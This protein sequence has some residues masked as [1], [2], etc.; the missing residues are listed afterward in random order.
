VG[1]SLQCCLRVTVEINEI[2]FAEHAKHH[3]TELAASEV[4]EFWVLA[5]S[6]S[7]KLLGKQMLFRGTVD[8]CMVHPRDVFRFAIQKNASSLIIAHNHPSGEAYPSDQDIKTTEQ[9][10]RAGRLLQI[11][12]LDHLLLTKT[13]FESFARK[14]WAKF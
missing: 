9:L 10:V 2:R 6:P 5:L 7:K 1:F 14:R 13:H 8:A 4:E 12:L 3:L 11:P